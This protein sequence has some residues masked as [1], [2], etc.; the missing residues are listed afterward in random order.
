MGAPWTRRVR[1]AK[2]G[3]L[4]PGSRIS[5]EVKSEASINSGSRSLATHR[6]NDMNAYRLQAHPLGKVCQ[7]SWWGHR[8]SSPIGAR[9]SRRTNRAYDDRTAWHAKRAWS[10]EI[11]LTWCQ[12]WCQCKKAPIRCSKFELESGLNRAEGGTRTPTPLRAQ[13]PK[14]C[15]ATVTPLPRMRDSTTQMSPF[16]RDNSG[17]EIADCV[18]CNRGAH[19]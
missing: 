1:P 4:K 2:Y 13:V 12:N 8:V 14:T 15:A 19:R 9:P 11:A 16:E 3:L 17:R 5:S 18:Q 6:G 10:H 7:L